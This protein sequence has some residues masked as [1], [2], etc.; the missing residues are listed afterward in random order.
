MQ[1]SSAVLAGTLRFLQRGL[2]VSA[3]APR[4]RRPFFNIHKKV[5]DPARQDPEYFEKAASA[6]PLDDNY[7]DALGKLYAEKVGSEREV[8]MKG[9]DR[10]IG[11]E[12]DQWL[13]AI[14]ESAP[15]MAYAHVD[16]L[17]AAP[18]FVKRIFSIEYGT[19][20][21]LTDA[22]KN[23]LIGQK[24]TWLTHR[25]FLMINFR[26]KLLRKLRETDSAAFE[27]VLSELKIAYHVPKLP[28]QMT[29]KRR[30]AWAEAQLKSRIE[31][32]KE[33]RLTELHKRFTDDRE[34]YEKEIDEKL[35]SLE[36]E[37]KKIEA[38]LKELDS[39]QGRMSDEFP[40]YQP[41]LIGSISERTIHGL[42]F[43][44]PKPLMGKRRL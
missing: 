5:T 3:F 44:H 12:R 19:R 4:A 9:E 24:P 21:D 6:L 23:V 26:R 1:P 39:L 34:K 20:R 41:S 38:R 22:W 15:R 17:T 35:V 13:P 32:E 11:K 10:L 16:A 43:Y 8:M 36:L 2:H 37:K 25:I 30:K 31:R 29:E 42:L 33:A 7:V 18:D 27:R 14:D 40:R 28:E